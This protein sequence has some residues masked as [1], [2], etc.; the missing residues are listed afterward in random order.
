MPVE[1]KKSACFFHIV[2]K[3]DT[4]FPDF[5]LLI[6]KFFYFLSFIDM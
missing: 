6:Y 3:T 4:S 1:Q 5:L 2:P